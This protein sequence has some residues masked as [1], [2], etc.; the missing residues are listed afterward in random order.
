MSY[1]VE[2][3]GKKI[4]KFQ[5]GCYLLLKGTMGQEDR[6]IHAIDKVT[7]NQIKQ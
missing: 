3:K 1:K 2:L 7:S 6:K 4:P 5:R